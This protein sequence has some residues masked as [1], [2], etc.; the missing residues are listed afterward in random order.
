MQQGLEEISLHRLGPVSPV[1]PAA[2]HAGEV[3]IIEHPMRLEIL[4]E[5]GVQSRLSLSHD[6]LPPDRAPRL[7]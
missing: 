2:E 6:N 4:P 5:P 3:G 1:S 7:L